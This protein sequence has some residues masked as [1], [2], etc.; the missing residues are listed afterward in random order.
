[1]AFNPIFNAVAADLNKER[2]RGKFFS[3]RAVQIILGVGEEGM[4]GKCHD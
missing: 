3:L 4:L 2:S 1:M